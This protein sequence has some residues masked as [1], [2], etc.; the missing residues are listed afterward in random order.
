MWSAGWR[1][2]FERRADSLHVTSLFPGVGTAVEVNAPLEVPHTFFGLTARSIADEAGALHQFIINGIRNGRPF[3][4]LVTYNTWFPYGVTVTEDAMV[5]EMDRAASLGV[6]LFVLDAGWWLGAGQDSDYDFDSGLGSWAEDPDRFPSSLASLRDY[7]HGLGM[8]FGIWVEPA[9]VALATV[10]K[11]GNAREPWLAQQGKVYGSANT[12]QVC[13]ASDAARQWVLG[14]LV[15]LIDRV[16]PDYLKWDEN[17]WINCNREGHGHGP[18]DGPFRHTKALYSILADLRRQFPDL[19]IENVSGG[20]NRM[21]FGMLAHTDVGWMDDR[22]APSTHVRH[23]LEGLT[24]A[25]PPAY[26]LSFAIDG[27]GEPISA[28]YD[29]DLFV[30]SRMPGTLGLTYRSDRLDEATGEMLAQQVREYKRIRDIIADASATLL[31]AQAPV[32]D[33]TW[34]VLQEVSRGGDA[35]VIFAFKDNDDDGRVL[36]RPRGL[37]ADAT[38]AVESLDAGAIG[39]AR[40]DTLMQDGLEIVHSGT[41]RAHVLIL[42]AR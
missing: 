14:K 18:D 36:V 3:T 9:R 38:Y 22:T 1:L 8:Q 39:S 5:T 35:A 31:S 21:D 20:G 4:P 29:L 10:D 42:T 41:S 40:G 34:D 32:T 30:R 2:A 33:G 13:L 27:E 25:F 23:N 12:A 7:A 26:L 19:M 15:D 28:G 37:V 11:P 17:F 24:F 6:E 16:R